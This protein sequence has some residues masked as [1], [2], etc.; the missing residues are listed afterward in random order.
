MKLCPNIRHFV[1][2]YII[3]WEFKNV[4]PVKSQR[5]FQFSRSNPRRGVVN[6]S[7]DVMYDM[8]WCTIWCMIW[9]TGSRSPVKPSPL[10]L[11]ILMSDSTLYCLLV[12]GRMMHNVLSNPAVSFLKLGKKNASSFTAVSWQ[13]ET[14]TIKLFKVYLNFKCWKHS[15]VL[16]T[17]CL[18]Y[19][20][21]SET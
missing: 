4:G 6:K 13:K 2:V 16:K 10:Q 21:T 12:S 5:N 3:I 11:P 8:M 9:E 7:L 20:E 19:K 15:R 1:N 14:F 18:Q 17:L